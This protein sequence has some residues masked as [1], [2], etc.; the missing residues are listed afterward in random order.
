MARL[1]I[2]RGSS[3]ND[4]TGDTLRSAAG[5]INDNFSELY[6]AFGTSADS[7]GSP[8]TFDSDG[9][10]FT[11]SEGHTTKLTFQ[12]PD[13]SGQTL[14]LENKSGVIPTIVNEGGHHGRVIDLRDS[15]G[16]AATAAK[17]YFGN[18]FDSFGDLPDALVYHGMFAFIHDSERAVV[19]HGNT[20]TD[21]VKILD[22]GTLSSGTYSINANKSTIQNLN[23]L[24]PR[25][26]STIL[27]SA[28]NEI[29][30]LETVG[31]PK[32]YVQLTAK[33]SSPTIAAV[34]DDPNIDLILKAKGTGTVS[35]DGGLDYSIRTV[36]N[37]GTALT[38]LKEKVLVLNPS[39]SA[40]NFTINEGSKNGETKTFIGYAGPVNGYVQLDFQGTK[41][42]EHRR[43]SSPPNCFVR[44][45]KGM[46]LDCIWNDSTDA[47]FTTYTGD[48]VTGLVTFP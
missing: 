37:N 36:D 45:Y 14:T 18:A 38:D 10:V 41:G 16:P 7:L 15:A 22:D 43:A 31:T 19:A 13:A 17:V 5:K 25:I 32:N 44:L 28:D 34:G 2:N 26:N 40:I 11:D 12:N 39:S 42:L 30:G 47:W 29:L 6:T 33:D 48:S 27:D 20:G 8:I 3:A 35:L 46:A 21:W 9:I 4:G 24:T 1:P 23:L